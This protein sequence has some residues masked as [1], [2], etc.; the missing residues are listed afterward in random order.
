[1]F[2]HRK[3]RLLNFK[4]STLVDFAYT[5]HTDLGNKYLSSVDGELKPPNTILK[6]GQRVVIEKS[7]IA[8]PDPSW[9]NFV[10]SVK[11]RTQ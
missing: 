11:A 8:K 5:I 1:M 2:S 3:A 6:N 9:L 4:K 10:T 7:D